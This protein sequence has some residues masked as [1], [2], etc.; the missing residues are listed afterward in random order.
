MRVVFDTNIFVSAL[1]LPGGRAEEALAR[2][3]K[4]RDCLILSKA[5]LNELLEVLSRKFKRDKE[6]LARVAI[7][8]SEI[9]ELVHPRRKL[10]VLED[11]PDNRILECAIS[12][13]AEMIVTGDRAMLNLGQYNEVKILSLRE[14][15]ALL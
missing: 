2:V 10:V 8:L 14:Y 1:A 15:L 5:I 7:F 9:G 11:E 13:K 12:G 3:V 6:A 4:G